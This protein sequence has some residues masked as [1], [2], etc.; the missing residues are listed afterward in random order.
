MFLYYALPRELGGE[1]DISG[2]E[3]EDR[4]HVQEQEQQQHYSALQ[5]T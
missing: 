3:H 5:D 2:G 4:D 1:H